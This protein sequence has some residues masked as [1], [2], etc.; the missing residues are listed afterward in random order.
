M[1]QNTFLLILLIWV[2]LLSH[3]GLAKDIKSKSLEGVEFLTGFSWGRLREKE[4]YQLGPFMVD[5]DFNL[6]GLT[7]KLNFAPKQLFQFQVEPFFSIVSQP[8]PNI[9][10]GMAF[11]LKF[12]LLPQ[13]SKF[14]PYIKGGVGMVYMTLKT[15]EQS[16]QFNFIEHGGIGMHYFFKK[17]IAFTLEGRIRHLS[18]AG[19]NHPNKGIETYFAL[20]GISYQF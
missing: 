10:T 1:K 4:N 14:Q 5:F 15:R 19:I 18:N 16:T 20:L 3:I 7:K 2:I 9:E 8:E 6:K 11:L 13:T 12:G 17:N